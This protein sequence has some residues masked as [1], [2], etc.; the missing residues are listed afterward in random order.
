MYKRFLLPYV[1]FLIPSLLQLLL[2]PTMTI[3]AEPVSAEDGRAACCSSA[4]ADIA[5]LH[6]NADRLHAQFKPKEAAGELQKILLLDEQNLEA[7]V[8]LSRA[9]IDI[10]DMI[11]ESSSQDA[12]ER[13]VKEYRIGEDYARKAIRANPNSTWGYFYLAASLGSI[14]ILSPVNKQI[15]IAAEIRGAVERA[16]ALDSQNGFAYHIY[17]VWHRKMAE[18][19]KTSRMFAPVLYGRS[20]PK[21]SLEKSI[22]YL[23]KAVALNPKVIVSRLEL[24]RSYVA[25]EN[26]TLARN[27]LIS[28]RELPN[29]FSDDAKHKQ[30]AEQL[31]EEIKER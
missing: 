25:A 27:S 21:G 1:L 3:G 17:G 20:I 13:K 23:Q 14:A 16:I 10:G 12:Q 28:V 7:L 31:L 8:K 5:Q 18:I 24:A 11:P 4:A 9:H 26:W 19:G 30:K 29:Q 6:K 15:D 22:E 2:Q